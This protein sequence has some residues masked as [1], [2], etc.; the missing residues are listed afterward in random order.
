MFNIG[1][2]EMSNYVNSILQMS[3]H[4]S[5]AIMVVLLFRFVLRK[6]PKKVTFGLWYVVVLRLICPINFGSWLSLFNLKHMKPMEK[7]ATDIGYN[8]TIV[9]PS[10]HHFVA[11][12]SNTVAIVKS[13]V[14]WKQIFMSAVVYIWI[15]G[16]ILISVYSICKLIK[17]RVLIKNSNRVEKNIFL[18]G[19]IGSPF[20]VGL[21]KPHIYMPYDVGEEYDYLLMHE[22]MHIKHK[23]HI[24]KYIAFVATIIHWFNPL[25]WLAFNL[26]CKDMEMRCDEYVI[27]ELGQDIKKKYSLSLVS[28]AA[29]Q[30][31]QVY[32]IGPIYFSVGKPGGMEVKMRVK[33]ILNYKKFSKLASV[34]VITVTAGSVLL[35]SACGEAAK[36]SKVSTVAEVQTTAETTVETTVETT[37]DIAEETDKEAAATDIVNSDSEN[38]ENV[39][40]RIKAE[41]ENIDGEYV[42][43]KVSDVD[44]SDVY[45]KESSEHSIVYGYDPKEKYGGSDEDVYLKVDN[46]VVYLNG[47]YLSE[48]QEL[49][50]AMKQGTVDESGKTSYVYNNLIVAP[51]YDCM[52]D[53]GLK[54]VREELSAEGYNLATLK[55][56]VV[57]GDKSLEVGL[58]NAVE[59]TKVSYGQDKRRVVIKLDDNIFFCDEC[60]GRCDIKNIGGATSLLFEDPCDMKGWAIDILGDT[61]VI[62]A[63]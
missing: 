16:V 56:T 55:E 58:V 20:V 31:P 17:L 8:R 47:G 63:E 57:V 48:Y 10:G 6:V 44:D 13:S 62:Y 39:S 45:V 3:L 24:F 26:L 35:L 23:D 50:E 37:G 27:D 43:A 30:R 40:I 32:V 42:K 41:E 28:Y 19:E 2:I 59:C 22:R 52:T 14:S 51:N 36:D 33:N 21:M 9:R 7:V 11:D 49:T 5:I 15:A 34:A 46:R 12:Y 61:N 4:A 54:E 18:S 38:G 1:G 25:A 29:Q 60:M 53:E